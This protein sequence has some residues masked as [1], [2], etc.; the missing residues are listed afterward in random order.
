MNWFAHAFCTPAFVPEG[1]W[2]LAGGKAAGRRPR[3]RVKNMVRPG[4]TPEPLRHLP[5]PLPG[6]DIYLVTFPGAAVRRWLTL[7]PAKF[8][9]PSGAMRGQLAADTFVPAF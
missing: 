8:P 1:R 7:P 5:A 6:C 9:C 2:N 3:N 4:G